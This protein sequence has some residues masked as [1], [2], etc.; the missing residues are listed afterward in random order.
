MLAPYP[1]L[2]KISAFQ[3]SR[4]RTLLKDEIPIASL[5]A[6]MSSSVLQVLISGSMLEASL[7]M[8]RWTP[9]Q[10]PGGR[11]VEAARACL[12]GPRRPKRGPV[13]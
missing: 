10:L 12:V 5:V 3:T 6:S 11:L 2:V 9:R 13:R 1:F 7:K 4:V 8:L